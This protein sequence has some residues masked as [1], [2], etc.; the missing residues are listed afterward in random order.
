[1]TSSDP[2]PRYLRLIRFAAGFMQIV[3]A[4]A[5]FLG[6][7]RLGALLVAGSDWGAAP[8][9]RVMLKEDFAATADVGSGREAALPIKLGFT[10]ARLSLPSDARW[11]RAFATL[12]FVMAATLLLLGS[13][14]MHRAASDANGRAPFHHSNYRHLRQLGGVFLAAW[15]WLAI[16]G[17][18]GQILAINRLGFEDGAPPSML[19]LNAIMDPTLWFSIIILAV[20]EIF[21]KGI[22]LREE[23]DLTV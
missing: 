9:L 1:M 5:L 13:R 8:E 14:I 3:A 22:H 20:A 2:L 21:R 23:N 11:L 15:M 10:A 17:V 7:V 12:D 16:S 6:L 18:I 19:L 4:G